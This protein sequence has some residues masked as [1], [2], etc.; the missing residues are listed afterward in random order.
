M[1]F[2]VL[3]IEKGTARKAVGLGNHIDRKINV[4]NA[5]P[6]RIGMN[7]TIVQSGD[8]MVWKHIK[9]IDKGSLQ[10]RVDNRIKEDYTGKRAIRKDA[11][12]H[13]NIVLTGSHE[14]MKNISNSRGL[15]TWL[16]DNYLFACNQ[17]GHED[18]VDFTLHMDERTP[19]IHCVVVPLTSDGRLSAKEVMGERNKMTKLQ[20]DYGKAMEKNNLQRGI[21]GSKATHDSLK[22]FYGRVNNALGVEKV[23]YKNIGTDIYGME[24][25][26]MPPLIGREK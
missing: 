21:K 5:D 12:T 20:N 14:E 26:E 19:H 8:K 22:E 16:K 7:Y 24:I 23:A 13:L 18:I 2:A 25:T 10:K 11:V 1:G 17:Y 15:S 9:E 6:K 3:H 4:S